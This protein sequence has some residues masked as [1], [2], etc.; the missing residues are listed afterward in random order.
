MINQIIRNYTREAGVRNLEK[1]IS[2]ICRKTVKKIETSSKKNINLDNQL[3]QNL[4]RCS[5]I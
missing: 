1:E 5:K 2:K 4:F 3:L